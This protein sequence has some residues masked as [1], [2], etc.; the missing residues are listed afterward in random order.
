MPSQTEK[1]LKPSI[2]R[3]KGNGDTDTSG[4]HSTRYQFYREA[5][6][7][8]TLN[9]TVHA[10][11]QVKYHGKKI[12]S[13]TAQ[14]FLNAMVNEGLLQKGFDANNRTIYTRV[15]EACHV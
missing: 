3:S 13:T 8:G 4:K 6:L 7:N 2:K 11:K 9:P 12:G 1:P 10:F 14:E 15:E 5:V